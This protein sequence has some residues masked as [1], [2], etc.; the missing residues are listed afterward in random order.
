[1]LDIHYNTS[2]GGK[3][4]SPLLSIDPGGVKYA[5]IVRTERGLSA[6]RSVYCFIDLATGDI[7]K[8]ASWKGPAKGVR[9]NINGPTPLAGC[10]PHGVVYLR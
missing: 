4:A 9:G 5:R 7:L 6:G 10:S 8:P 1:M 3:L 2:Y